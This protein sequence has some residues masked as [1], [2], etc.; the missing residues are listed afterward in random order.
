VLY[1]EL[2]F[3]QH[4]GILDTWLQRKF[5]APEIEPLISEDA[6][7]S[8]VYRDIATPNGAQVVADQQFHS[9]AKEKLDGCDQCSAQCAEQADLYHSLLS[10]EWFRLL[11][12][13]PGETNDQLVCQLRCAQRSET[14]SS[15]EA[16][17][18]SWNEPCSDFQTFFSTIVC[19]GVEI[20]I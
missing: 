5:S 18:Y 8:I 13:E 2:I 6:S 4:A 15:Y 19:R 7:K 3:A 20:Q 14:T 9:S 11:I 10:Q 16:L 17:S 12:I 1:V